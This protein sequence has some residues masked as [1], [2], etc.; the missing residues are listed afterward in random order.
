MIKTRLTFCIG[1][2]A[3]IA[4]MS[5]HLQARQLPG[6][7]ALPAPI[8]FSPGD[9]LVSLEPGPVVWFN[10]SGIPQRPLVPTVTG[11]GEGMAFDAAWNLYVARWCTDPSCTQ[12]G[13]AVEKYNTLGLSQG[14]VGSNFNCSP[15][16]IAFDRSGA[17]Y[18]GQAGCNRTILKFAPGGTAPVAEYSVEQEGLGVFWMDLAPDGCT[19]FYTSVGPNIKRFDVCTN[20]QLANFNAGSLPGAFTHDLRVLPDGGV[21][22]ANANVV[23]RLNASGGVTR[24]YEVPENT[25]FAGLDLVGDGTFWVGNYYTSS[26]YRFDLDTGVQLASFNTGTP[27]NS[28]VG[29]KVKR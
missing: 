18:I 12:T 11:L 6:L 10:S 9:V 27:A 8:M 14:A 17:V 29:I 4:A 28:V 22:V 5:L 15:H 2:A 26:I 3:V 23:T 20:T 25:L 7:P 24:T 13:N 21:I 19:M 1:V 16:T